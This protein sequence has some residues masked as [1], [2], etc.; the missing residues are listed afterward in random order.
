M[1]RKTDGTQRKLRLKQ[2]ECHTGRASENVQKIVALCHLT[3]GCF[4]TQHRVIDNGGRK[5]FTATLPMWS[6]SRLF[7]MQLCIL[8]ISW[9]SWALWTV[10]MLMEGTNYNR[11]HYGESLLGHII[12]RTN[13]MVS[14]GKIN[15]ISFWHLH[16]CIT[17][18]FQSGTDPWRGSNWR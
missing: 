4:S 1:R 9:S 14:S 11:E 8:V 13:F 6:L 17:K 5:S 10:C 12:R 7:S 18:K 16:M 15:S 2:A 3:L